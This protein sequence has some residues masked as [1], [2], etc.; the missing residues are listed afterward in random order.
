MP[1]KDI[2][3]LHNLK[4]IDR[5]I[6]EIELR[7]ETSVSKRAKHKESNAE[8]QRRFKDKHKR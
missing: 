4:G 2:D 8:R 1:V 3:E 5:L 6:A 7:K